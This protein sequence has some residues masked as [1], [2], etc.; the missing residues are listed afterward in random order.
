MFRYLKIIM[1]L[2]SV[3]FK[4]KK[5]IVSVTIRNIIPPIK[6]FFK[7]CCLSFHN[8]RYTKKLVEQ[9]TIVNKGSVGGLNSSSPTISHVRL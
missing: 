5:K 3:L 4:K 7:Y 2:I 1:I 6:F 9:I 8:K